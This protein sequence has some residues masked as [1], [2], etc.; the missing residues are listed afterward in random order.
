MEGRKSKAILRTTPNRV[1]HQTFDGFNMT[2]RLLFGP[3]LQ[4][5][6]KIAE[7]NQHRRKR[8]SHFIVQFARERPPLGFLRLYQPR[9]EVLE[10]AAGVG[11]LLVPQA[12]LIL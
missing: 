4:A 7:F 2:A 3:N 5:C 8:L 12:G 1:F 11:H 6:R 10:L 9:R